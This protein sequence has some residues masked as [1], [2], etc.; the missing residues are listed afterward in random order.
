MTVIARIKCDKCGKEQDLVD[1]D[2]APDVWVDTETM[3]MVIELDLNQA[4]FGSRHLCGDCAERGWYPCPHCGMFILD[5][6]LHR[7]E[8]LGLGNLW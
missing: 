7:C 4:V 1:G 6:R 3:E 5:D 8:K 2:L